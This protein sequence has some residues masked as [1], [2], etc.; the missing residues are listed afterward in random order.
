MLSFSNDCQHL[1]IRKSHVCIF[2]SFLVFLE[3]VED[4]EMLLGSRSVDTCCGLTHLLLV[5]VAA[6]WTDR[7]RV[8]GVWMFI[9]GQWEFGAEIP[10]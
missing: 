2:S 4:L 8:L 1:P 3:K 5:P 9:L 10:Q 6:F 7:A